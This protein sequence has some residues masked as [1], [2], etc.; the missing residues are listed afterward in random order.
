MRV[1]VVTFPG[2]NCDQDCYRA[3]EFCGG[4]L[5]V[6]VNNAGVFDIRAF[7]KVDT[8]SMQRMI[9]VN[10][11]GLG[12]PHPRLRDRVGHY[13]LLMK[14]NHAIRDRTPAKRSAKPMVGVHG[15]TSS[16]EMRVPLVLASV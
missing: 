1:V 10:Y 13:C 16:A 2:S 3:V 4:T 12:M 7:E 9:E 8:E 5:D 6:L 14:G 11:F 15:G